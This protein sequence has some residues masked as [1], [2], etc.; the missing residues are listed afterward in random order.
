MESSLLFCRVCRLVGEALKIVARTVDLKENVAE[1]EKKVVKR[2]KKLHEKSRKNGNF[3][4][5]NYAKMAKKKGK[6]DAVEMDLPTFGLSTRTNEAND[7]KLC[8]QCNEF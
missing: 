3:L 5:E 4:N 8:V 7:E 6:E 2:Q 1:A